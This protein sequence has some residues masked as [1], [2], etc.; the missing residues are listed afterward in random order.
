MTANGA[1]KSR[2]FSHRPVKR[3]CHAAA[4]GVP[5]YSRANGDKGPAARQNREFSEE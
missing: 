1:Q 4:F 2:Q 5:Y 3:V